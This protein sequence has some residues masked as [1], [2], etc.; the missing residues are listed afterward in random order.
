MNFVISIESFTS[1]EAITR[2]PNRG[3]P[4]FRTTERSVEPRMPQ[5]ID[6]R[7]LRACKDAVNISP[8][9]NTIKSGEAK[10]GF[11]V[12]PVI[13]SVSSKF[14]FFMPINT[15]KNPMPMAMPLRMLGLM[16]SI[17]F[18]RTPSIERMRNNTPE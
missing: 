13:G 4:S 11:S 12:Q 15:I 10:R 1:G 9:K 7:T 18:S 14:V 6:P 17:S 8:K 5:M 2:S 16:A 3:K